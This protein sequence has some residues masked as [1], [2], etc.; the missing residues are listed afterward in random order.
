MY[1]DAK[2]CYDQIP[3]NISNMSL[4][5]EGLP[6]EIAKLHSQTFQSI[7][8]QIKHKQ[9]IGSHSH[10]HNHPAP[11]YGVGQGSTDASARWSFLS[12]ALIRAFSS[13]AHDATIKSPMHTQTTNYKIQGF[14][15]DTTN[16]FKRHHTMAVFMILIAQ[17]GAQLW[18]R[19]LHASG[20]K[21]EIPKCTFSLFSWYF[22]R[23]GRA[24]LLPSTQQHL[25]VRRSETSNIMLVPQLEPSTAYKYVGV[26][27]ALNGSMKKQI[28]TLKTKCIKINGAL[29]QV[30]T[31]SKD[32]KQ[33]YTTVFIPSITYVLPAASIQEKDL[34]QIQ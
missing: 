15:D 22:N 29:S 7:E 3:E 14:V 34:Q 2:A 23:M 8:Y 1:N 31:T 30:Y 28:T 32:T 17:H 13:E 27:I 11:I 19:L 20:G 18:E 33:G 21:L 16:L 26:Q 12:D 25:H 24:I 10:K 4:L 5:Q 6:L 9:G